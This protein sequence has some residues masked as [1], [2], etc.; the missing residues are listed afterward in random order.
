MSE[1]KASDRI[2]H[3]DGTMC[4]QRLF[5]CGDLKLSLNNRGPLCPLENVR[6]RAGASRYLIYGASAVHGYLH[7]CCCVFSSG[8]HWHRL[9]QW[10]PDNRSTSPFHSVIVL[11]FIGN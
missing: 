7:P 11:A 4:N 2:Q 3:A 5:Y 9:G 10:D 8:F 1:R 6:R